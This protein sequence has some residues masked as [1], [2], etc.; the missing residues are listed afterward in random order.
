MGW[1]ERSWVFLDIIY[2]NK[3]NAKSSVTEIIKRFNKLYDSFPVEITPPHATSKVVFSRAFKSYFGFTVRERKSLTLD[4]IQTDAL[5]VEANFQQGS[6]REREN[7]VIGQR[8]NRKPIPLVKLRKL[9][10][11][12]WMRWISWL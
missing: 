6:G 1:E 3:G 9:M 8:E 12:I 5:E 2:C 11:I 4:Q 7:I 10:S